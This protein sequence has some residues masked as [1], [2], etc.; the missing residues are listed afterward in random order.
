VKVWLITGAASGF[1]LV[2]ALSRRDVRDLR[3][4]SGIGYQRSSDKVR[5]V[6]VRHVGPNTTNSSIRNPMEF[7]Y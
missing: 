2:Q 3:R 4:F 6:D 5:H 1:G 7:P